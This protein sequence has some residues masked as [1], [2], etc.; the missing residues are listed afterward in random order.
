MAESV[1]EIVTKSSQIT[2]FTNNVR[3]LIRN[4]TVWYT[5]SSNPGVGFPTSYLGGGKDPGGPATS[6]LSSPAI[7]AAVL[8]NAFHAWSRQYTR[9]RR[10]RFRRTGNL[11]PYDNT[12]ITHMNDSFRQPAEYTDIDNTASQ[13][14]VG[15][16]QLIDASNF[17]DFVSAI[18]TKWQAHKNNTHTYTFYYCHSSCHSSCHGSGRG[19]R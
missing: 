10:F 3:N 16:G 19:R 9:V 1:G 18:Y 17:N 2:E 13:N 11:S 15:S 14:S 6:E 8:A 12:E 7:D 5:G 4:A